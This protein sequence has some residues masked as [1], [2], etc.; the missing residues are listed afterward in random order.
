MGFNIHAS[1]PQLAKRQNCL[2]HSFVNSVAE[3]E[4]FKFKCLSLIY[5]I[6]DWSAYGGAS[7]KC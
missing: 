7:N 6:A 3:L 4:I 1:D 5:K 2:F